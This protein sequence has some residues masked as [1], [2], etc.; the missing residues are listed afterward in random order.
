MTP[1][2]IDALTSATQRLRYEHSETGRRIIR[3]WIDT[4]LDYANALK[5]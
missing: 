3:R 2:I 4:L 1:E 5:P